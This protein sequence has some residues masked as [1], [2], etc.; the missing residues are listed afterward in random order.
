VQDDPK[1]SPAVQSLENEQARLRDRAVDSDL[2]KGLQDSFPASD[3]VSM[4][5]TSV[6]SG[7]TDPNQA[8]WTLAEPNFSPPGSTARAN[9]RTVFEDLKTVVRERPLAA[10]GVV[11]AVGY[12]W[13]LT[14]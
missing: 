1:T 9:T 10:I 11:A 5:R 3:P 2:D 14:R 8:E 12:L 4:I 13:G 6:A 7:Q